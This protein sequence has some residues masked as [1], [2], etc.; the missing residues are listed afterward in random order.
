MRGQTG[1]EYLIMIGGV[2]IVALVIGAYLTTAASKIY[3]EVSGV[4][5]ATL[6]VNP[7]PNKIAYWKDTNTLESA[8]FLTVNNSAG[9]LTA[10]GKIVA[11]DFCTVTGKCLSTAGGGGGSSIWDVNGSDIYYTGGKVGI[12][13]SAPSADLE[14]NVSGEPGVVI[15]SEKPVGTVAPTLRLKDGVSGNWFQLRYFR[16]GNKLFIESKSKGEA[17]TVTD[18]G[19]VGIGVTTPS[20]ELDVNG[21]VF[22]EKSTGCGTASLQISGICGPAMPLLTPSNGAVEVA[23]N[24]IPSTPSKYVLGGIPQ[25]WRAVYTYSVG[26]NPGH[27]SLDFNESQNTATLHANKIQLEGNVCINGDCRLKW[28]YKIYGKRDDTGEWVYLGD[29]KEWY[30]DSS[31]TH[32]VDMNGNVWAYTTSGV[33]KNGKIYYIDVTKYNNPTVDGYPIGYIGCVNAKAAW[34]VP[35]SY[36]ENVC[37]CLGHKHMLDYSW[38]KCSGSGE[39]FYMLEDAPKC[40]RDNGSCSPCHTESTDYGD[41]QCCTGKITSITCA[42][43]LV[44]LKISSD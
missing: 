3:N 15:T 33:T 17:V 31:G 2:L 11:D 5:G 20:A 4:S 38:T 43:K 19:K 13:T 14:V 26:Y 7:V 9:T 22:L 40:T 12:G 6:N 34:I 37:E 41:I 21:D 10:S 29:L 28:A 30:V 27:L 1:I 23:G 42:A 16:S 25:L 35:S 44:A 39:N 36:A 24:I 8:T 18:D 32:Y